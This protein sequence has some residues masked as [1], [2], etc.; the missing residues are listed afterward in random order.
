MWLV[1]RLNTYN[2]SRSFS[3]CL[4]N[5]LLII[6]RVQVLIASIAKEYQLSC[7]LNGSKINTKIFVIL[8]LS[9]TITFTAYL[10]RVRTFNF[11]KVWIMRRARRVLTVMRARMTQIQENIC[12]AF[13]L[14]KSN[15]SWR[16]TY[17]KIVDFL[18]CSPYYLSFNDQLSILLFRLS[19]QL[20]PGPGQCLLLFD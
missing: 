17:S 14:A 2:E 6:L 8:P 5:H 4:I 12:E 10:N 7:N 11:P 16:H 20:G 1:T 9:I 19:N 18:D 13:G 3:A 15:K